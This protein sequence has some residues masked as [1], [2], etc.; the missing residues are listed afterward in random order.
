ME[1]CV[2]GTPN[3]V[4][5]ESICACLKLHESAPPLSLEGLREFVRGK[6]AD[7]KLPDELLLF[8]DFP[9]LSGGIK[10][11]RFGA[12]GVVEVATLSTD[13]QTLRR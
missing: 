12:G 8:E 6:V 2:V 4:L 13:K 9:R 11:K 3:P 10:L 7:F 1:A 5:G